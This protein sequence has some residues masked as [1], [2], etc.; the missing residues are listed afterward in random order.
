M[1]GVN[2]GRSGQRRWWK[3]IF[4]SLGLVSLI[5]CAGSWVLPFEFEVES[6]S[7]EIE[8]AEIVPCRALEGHTPISVTNIF[9]END[10]QIC[11]AVKAKLKNDVEE[12]RN[13]L[14]PDTELPSLTVIE[15]YEGHRMGEEY[16][17]SSSYTPDGWVTGGYCVEIVEG[18]LPKGRYRVEIKILSTEVGAVEYQVQ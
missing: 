14:P 7:F 13:A 16:L 11:I 1:R 12:I 2:E 17:I 3:D 15:Y 8:R 4:I 10:P 5:S 18:S 6:L 9:T